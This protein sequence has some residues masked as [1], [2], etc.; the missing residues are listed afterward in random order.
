MRKLKYYAYF[1]LSFFAMMVTSWLMYDTYVS[2]NG[3]AATA[4]PVYYYCILGAVIIFCIIVLLQTFGRIRKY[5]KKVKRA[6]E[7]AREKRYAAEEAA[8]EAAGN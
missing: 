1:G 4:V 2:D 3:S 6:N 8:A 7:R 5:S